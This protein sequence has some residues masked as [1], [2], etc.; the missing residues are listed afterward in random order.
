[1]YVYKLNILIHILCALHGL[2]IGWQ[3]KVKE[4]TT[5]IL[6][7]STKLSFRIDLFI[8]RTWVVHE[9]WCD[10]QKT[11]KAMHYLS[12]TKYR[13]SQKKVIYIVRWSPVKCLSIVF[14]PIKWT[15]SVCC[16]LKYNREHLTLGMHSKKKLLRRRHWS[17]WEGGG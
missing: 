6:W 7:I 14:S 11:I 10:Y 17:I 9:E 5:Y 2:D 12:R 3:S 15:D 8:S 16:R 1:M 4:M 13:V